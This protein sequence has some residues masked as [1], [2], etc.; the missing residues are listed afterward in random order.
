[1]AQIMT[2]Y[3][4]TAVE[5]VWLNVY[6]QAYTPKPKTKIQLARRALLE[7]QTRDK[8]AVAVCMHHSFNAP[9]TEIVGY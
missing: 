4:L 3:T 1:M 8:S 5:S 6:T 9:V 7:L 2:T